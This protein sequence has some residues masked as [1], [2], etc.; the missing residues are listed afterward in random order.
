MVI[1]IYSHPMALIKEKN[2]HFATQ[3][4]YFLI[5]HH[6]SDRWVWSKT[7]SSDFLKRDL[8]WVTWFKESIFLSKR[9]GFIRLGTLLLPQLLD[10]SGNTWTGHAEVAHINQPRDYS[11]LEKGT[12]V[13]LTEA[14]GV[15]SSPREITVILSL[16]LHIYDDPPHRRSWKKK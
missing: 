2:L 14:D 7:S 4:F 11:P 5:L 10:S 16:S 8:K 13:Q 6:S 9:S 15:K 3:L 1:S 12:L